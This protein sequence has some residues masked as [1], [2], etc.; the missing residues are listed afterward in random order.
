[1]AHYH[2][3]GRPR[4]ERVCALL[5]PEEPLPDASTA[6]TSVRARATTTVMAVVEPAGKHSHIFWPVAGGVGVLAASL[7]LYFGWQEPAPSSTNT[8][9]RATQRPKT[10]LFS[11]KKPVLKQEEWTYG[12]K[13]KP[14]EQSLPSRKDI[15]RYAKEIEALKEKQQEEMAALPAPPQAP[16]AEAE[17]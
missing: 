14:P 7:V 16:P 17:D 8:M 2:I 5:S 13:G 9:R 12:R 3:S 4:P 15:A 6:T 11:S 1:M 10:S